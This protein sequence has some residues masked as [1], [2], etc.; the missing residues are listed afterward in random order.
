MQAYSDSNSSFLILAFSDRHLSKSSVLI[1]GSSDSPSDS[2]FL[3]L[4][5]V[6]EPPQ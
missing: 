1:L 6:R 4:D 5:L 3:S 2:S